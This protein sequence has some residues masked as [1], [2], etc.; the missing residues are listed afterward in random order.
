MDSRRL[1]AKIG[2]GSSFALVLF[3]STVWARRLVQSAVAGV[4][5]DLSTKIVAAIPEWRPIRQCRGD[6]WRPAV[7]GA[8]GAMEHRSLPI[9]GRHTFFIAMEPTGC[10]QQKLTPPGLVTWDHFGAAVAISGD[11]ILIGAPG[12]V[13]HMR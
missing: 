6:R 5:C 1:H 13:F 8:P 7:C 3:V 12:S 4:D 9:A 10:Q 11:T 2:R